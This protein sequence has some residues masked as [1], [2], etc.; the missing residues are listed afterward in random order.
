MLM[1][2]GI[3]FIGLLITQFFSFPSYEEQQEYNSLKYLAH[4]ECMSVEEY[5][6]KENE[7]M[8]SVAAD[9]RSI[10][11]AIVDGI[12]LNKVDDLPAALSAVKDFHG[13][14]YDCDYENIHQGFPAF[15]AAVAS[16]NYIY[17]KTLLSSGCEVAPAA[18]LRPSLTD[19]IMN[20]PFP[21]R[22]KLLR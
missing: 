9:R 16:A 21:E 6:K 12:H 22:L 13:D 17:L 4:L 3:P 11:E 8:S 1:V 14:D 7:R 10:N 5:V 15:R 19:S 2:V 20:S 18:P